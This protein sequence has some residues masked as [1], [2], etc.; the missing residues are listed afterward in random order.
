MKNLNIEVSIRPILTRHSKQ[1][2]LGI[3]IDLSLFTNL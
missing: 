3:H 1:Q 2:T